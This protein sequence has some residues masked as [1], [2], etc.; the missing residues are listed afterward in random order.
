VT[1]ARRA[2]VS[3]GAVLGDGQIAL[4]VDLDAMSCNTKV[5]A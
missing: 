2:L 3:G 5:A 1:A 4:I